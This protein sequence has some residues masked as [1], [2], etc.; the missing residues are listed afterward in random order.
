[1]GIASRVHFAGAIDDPRAFFAGGDALLLPTYYDPCS[2]AVLEALSCG[3]PVITTRYNGAAELLEE[4]SSGFV[5]TEPSEVGAMAKALLEIKA[6]WKSFH[7]AALRSRQA[8]GWSA[9]VDRMERVLLGTVGT[10]GGKT[11]AI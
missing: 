9:H 2:L 4:G 6:R 7:E 10:A 11:S 5:V 8:L 3:T 1:M